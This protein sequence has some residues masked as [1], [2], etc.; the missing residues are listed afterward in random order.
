MDRPTEINPSQLFRRR[1]SS[2]TTYRVEWLH[3]DGRVQ[4][5]L[6]R[7]HD[8]D[9]DEEHNIDAGF[10][11]GLVYVGMACIYCGREPQAAS[12]EPCKTCQALFDDPENTIGPTITIDGVE[13][14]KRTEL[15]NLCAEFLASEARKERA[16]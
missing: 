14:P 13:V 6:S 10:L 9:S 16:S 5:W 12:N 15:Y 2:T 7:L 8:D 4:L 11:N 1:I 3:A